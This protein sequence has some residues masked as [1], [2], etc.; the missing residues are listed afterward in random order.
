MSNAICHTNK[1]IPQEMILGNLLF[2]NLA[3]MKIPVASLLGIFQANQIPESYVRTISAA[4]AFRRAS[5]SLKSTHLAITDSNGNVQHVKVEVDE[6]R[7]DTDSIKRI[8]G[9][10]R[11]DQVSE[12]IAYD[13]IAETIFNR[14][15][16]SCVATPLVFS[17]DPNYA[18]YR[19][20]C[21][22]C[23]NRYSDWSV[24]HNKDTVRNIINR[25]IA[26]THPINLMPTGLCKFTPASSAQ[27]LYNLKSALQEMNAF[28]TTQGS[29]GNIMEI[30]PVIDTVEQRDLIE[31]NFTAEITD[32][33]L[34]LVNE[35]K[36]VLTARQSINTRTA[37]AYTE[38]FKL[39]K[40]KATDYENLLGIYVASIQQQLAEA[41]QLIDD[42]T[43]T[44]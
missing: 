28:T 1:D 5:S 30:I 44:D 20:L 25:I 43:E 17:S 26:D 40:E 35:L 29:A 18:I 36:G 12:D 22:T 23:I 8:I 38:K 31:K 32:E 41:L 11:I 24:Y 4:D 39:L 21:D 37:T 33:L 3:D 9:I 27:L 7:C 10:K 6:V 13:P 14:Q 19:D 2:T 42:N 34:M 16:C 15:Q